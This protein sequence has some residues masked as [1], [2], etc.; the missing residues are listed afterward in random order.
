MTCTDPAPTEPEEQSPVLYVPVRDTGAAYAL[1]LFRQ[2]DGSRC[3]VGFTS[4]TALTLLLGPAQR[5]VVL[6]EAALRALAEP[7]GATALVVDPQL[8]APPVMPPARIPAAGG[9]ATRLPVVQH[10]S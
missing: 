10:Q 4:T 3:A 2:R 7:L 8:V 6:A 9:L 1:R 5:S